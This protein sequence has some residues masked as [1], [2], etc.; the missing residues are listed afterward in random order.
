MIVGID[1]GLQGAISVISSKGELITIYDMPQLKTGVGDKRTYDIPGIKQIINELDLKSR[2]S[3]DCK[4]QVFIENVSALPPGY[5]IQASTGLAECKGIFK[6]MLA[7]KE[8]K[9]ELVA[10]KKWHTSFGITK[11]KGDYKVQSYQ[12]AT[13]LFPTAELTTVR[14]RKL[15]GRSDALLIAEWGRRQLQ[16]IIK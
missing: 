1:L 16:G 9:Y 13:Q 7:I 6:G 3:D 10:A 2:S 11:D 8:I 12:V 14:G 4:I 15:D 5:A